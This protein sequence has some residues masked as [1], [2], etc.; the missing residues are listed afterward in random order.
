MFTL[1]YMFAVVT[2]PEIIE[3]VLKTCLEKDDLMRMFRVLLGNGNIFAPVSIWRPRRKILA[4]TFSQK[5]LNSFV[6]IF[7]RQ[8]KVMSDQ[9]QIATQK[10]P[11]S[12]W[13]YIST[14]TMDSVCLS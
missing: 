12:M 6:D 10:G 11:I 9:L 14:Y 1:N 5:N 13:K 4:P 7:A 3:I 8:S 2:E